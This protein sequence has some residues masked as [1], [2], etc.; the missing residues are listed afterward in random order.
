MTR[1]T[2]VLDRLSA[3]NPVD[4]A[5]PVPPAELARIEARVRAARAPGAA[6]RAPRARWAR[7]PRLGLAGSAAAL[8]AVAAILVATLSGGGVSPASAAYAAFAARTGVFRTVAEVIVQHPGQRATH[9][10][11]ESWTAAHGGRS[12]DLQ[13]NVRPDGRRG[14][15]VSEAYHSGKE[16]GSGVVAY[17]GPSPGGEVGLSGVESSTGDPRL[18][19]LQ[20]YRDGRVRDAGTATVQLAGRPHR[21]WRLVAEERVGPRV[22][23]IYGRRVRVPGFV[24]HSTF[25]VDVRTRALLVA[26][27]TGLV[28]TPHG[29]VRQTTIR[30]FLRF[31]RVHSRAGLRPT[32][33]FRRFIDPLNQRRQSRRSRHP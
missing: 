3:A 31:D 9:A 10:W 6:T 32:P 5:A 21:A 29:Y 7:I 28:G 16:S 24:A 26:Q 27:H 22:N 20:A 19:Y 33:R 12:H 30:R 15:L 4:A 25:L 13:Y 1:S 11:V 18:A 2:A 23:E 8:A 17:A 14:R